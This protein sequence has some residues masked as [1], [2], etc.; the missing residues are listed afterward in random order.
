M[1]HQRAWVPAKAIL[2]LWLS[3]G[4]TDTIQDSRPDYYTLT[5][6]MRI[7]NN[8]FGNEAKYHL[9]FMIVALIKTKVENHWPRAWQGENE[10]P[11]D[12]TLCLRQGTG[13]GF[14]S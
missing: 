11:Q 13:E 14:C 9:E 4:N 3:S 8:G 12:S 6:S 7:H 10:E 1:Y 5:L 2:S